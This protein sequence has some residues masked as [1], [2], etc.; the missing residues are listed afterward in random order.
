[1]DYLFLSRLCGGEVG[2]DFADLTYTFLSRLCGGEA[3]AMSGR[4]TD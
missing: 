3:Q 4:P 1:M 2:N